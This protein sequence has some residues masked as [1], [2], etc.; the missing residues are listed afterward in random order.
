MTLIDTICN[1][2]RGLL[3][4]GAILGA[5]F[6]PIAAAQAQNAP[7]T[8]KVRASHLSGTP[9]VLVLSDLPDE[10]TSVS[11][12]EWTMLGPDSW[13]HHNDFTIP[14]GPAVAVM[15]ADKF[16]GYCKGA[17]DIVAHTDSGDYF[18]YLDK[19]AGNWDASTTLTFNASG[20]PG[21][22]TANGAIKVRAS[23]LSGTPDVLVISTVPD[24][25][26]SIT[27]QEWTMLGVDS[28]KHHN[29]FTIPK[30]PAVAV[31]NADKF[32][33]YCK[34]ADDIVAH[35]DS[36]DYIGHLDRGAG[37]WDGSTTLTIK[38]ADKR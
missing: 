28:W 8:L 18:G 4:G 12:Q 35:T 32:Q 31:M 7:A 3:V 24:E 13:K 33:G 38:A 22:I 11:C 10:I 26:T 20:K 2:T 1:A 23:H 6:G 16:Q 19:G 36:G 14:K 5:T 27:C 17:Q 25:I 15:N 34:G 37:N 9:L 21:A 30:G 29:D